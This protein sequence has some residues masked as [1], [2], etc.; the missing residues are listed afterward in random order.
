[1]AAEAVGSTSLVGGAGNN[2]VFVKPVCAEAVGGGAG[3]KPVCAE[4]VAEAVFILGE[5]VFFFGK[6]FFVFGEVVFVLTEAVFVL[7]ALAEAVF[8]LGVLLVVSVVKPL[9]I[10]AAVVFALRLVF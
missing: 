6:A 5:S 9:S 3:N 2:Q 7:E 8:I 10:E 4:A 1:V